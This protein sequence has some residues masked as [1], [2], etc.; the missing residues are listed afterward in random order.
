MLRPGVI[1]LFMSLA[2][3]PEINGQQDKTLYFTN[4]GR[5]N[6]TSDA[7]LEVI[8]ASSSKLA[9][10]LNLTD[11]SFAFS[12]PMRSFEGFN[13]ALQRTHF[14][15][16]YLETEKYPKARFNGKIIEE[17]DLSSPGTVQVRAKGKLLIHGLEEDRIIRCMMNIKPGKIDVRSEFTVPLEDH[18]I[19]IPSIVQQKI[20]EIIDVRIQFT[21]EEMK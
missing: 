15:E 2:F 13:S 3:S 4:S 14:N 21:L 8:K 9:G 10:V 12:I 5:V 18:D 11:R 7:P 16:N 1:I 6:F 17:I 19:A 20:A